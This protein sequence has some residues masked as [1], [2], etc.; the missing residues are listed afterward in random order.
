MG[1]AININARKVDALR[2]IVASWA[3]I[4]IDIVVLRTIYAI[5]RREKMLIKTVNK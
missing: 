2:A 3:A 1:L 4:S 5:Y